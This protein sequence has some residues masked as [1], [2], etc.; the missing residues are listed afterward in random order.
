MRSAGPGRD[1]GQA[2]FGVWIAE[3]QREDLTLL[4]GGPALSRRGRAGDQR[5]A[6]QDLLQ[7]HDLPGKE[8]RDRE[9]DD[10]GRRIDVGDDATRLRAGQ[11][12]R[13]G[14]EPQQELVA[15]DGVDVEVD[16]DF[17]RPPAIAARAG[18]G[19]RRPWWRRPSATGR[20]QSFLPSLPL[21]NRSWLEVSRRMRTGRVL[22]H[23]EHQ[24]QARRPWPQADA[25][26]V[27]SLAARL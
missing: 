26:A 17:R 19:S 6:V 13:L 23:H 9:P 18:E 2:E 11:A 22:S 15:V 3:Q 21:G 7:V 14:A 5:E 1:L 20:G 25:V 12:A 4:L 16:R 10:I 27:D 24:N 8:L